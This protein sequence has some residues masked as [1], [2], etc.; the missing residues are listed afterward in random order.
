M[1]GFTKCKV[2][3]VEFALI[4]INHY[5]AREAWETGLAAAI[6]S[7]QEVN[8]YDAFDCPHCGCQ[9]IMQERKRTLIRNCDIVE[10]A[11]ECEDEAE[12]PFSEV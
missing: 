1:D 12:A 3:G 8:L 9:N 6:R 2:C 5:V 4:A 10:D 7:S 11:E